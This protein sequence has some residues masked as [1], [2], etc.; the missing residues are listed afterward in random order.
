MR[1][2][3]DK[4]AQEHIDLSNA[5]NEAAGRVSIFAEKQKTKRRPVR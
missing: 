2:Q 1:L 3:S 5:L 4:M